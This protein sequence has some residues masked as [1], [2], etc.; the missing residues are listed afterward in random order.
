MRM[1][2]PTF[3]K[4]MNKAELDPLYLPQ[5]A[6]M[7][8]KQQQ[9]ANAGG[10]KKAKRGYVIVEEIVPIAGAASSSSSSEGM[11]PGT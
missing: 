7:L 4:E 9:R 1:D 5:F 2:E 10:V 11:L 8:A 3:L 6:K